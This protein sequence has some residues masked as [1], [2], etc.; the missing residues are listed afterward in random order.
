MLA[1]ELNCKELELAKPAIGNAMA[2]GIA[3]SQSHAK[4]WRARSMTNSI[5]R[6]VVAA[7]VT[8]L[9]IAV[10]WWLTTALGWLIG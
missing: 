8:L 5:T 2:G 3:Q 9:A 10:I 1:I 7:I 6:A 4:A